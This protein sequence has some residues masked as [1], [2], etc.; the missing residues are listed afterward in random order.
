MYIHTHAYTYIFFH[1]KESIFS[2]KT[3]LE[4]ETPNGTH[5]CSITEAKDLEEGLDFTQATTFKVIFSNDKKCNVRGK[6]FF[7]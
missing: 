1:K 6:Y 3:K 5:C 7:T 2:G 4:V